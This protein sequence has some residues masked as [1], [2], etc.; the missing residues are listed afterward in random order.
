MNAVSFIRWA[1]A[2]SVLTLAID[3]AASADERPHESAVA[4]D[5][6]PT[7][8]DPLWLDPV[9]HSRTGLLSRSIRPDEA[10]GYF[11]IL[12]HAHQVPQS[13]LQGAARRFEKKRR[14]I[15]KN[16]PDY[17]FYFRDPHAKFP[18][19]FD[20]HQASEAYH[21]KLVT[22]RGHV[23]RLVSFPAGQ[24]AHGFQELHE[25]WLYVDDAQQNPVVI[26]CSEL[27]SGIPTGGDLLVDFVSATGYFFKRYGY[28]DRNGQARFSP[29]ILAQR[30]E[31]SPPS[32][33][34]P[35]LSTVAFFWLVTG[36]A[37][38]IAVACWHAAA[39]RHTP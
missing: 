7:E 10:A 9:K 25:A 24:N 19:F 26:V 2:L 33:R 15:V 21:G 20:L 23:R 16:D 37:V 8:L 35:L 3:G 5:V 6:D 28:E 22:V 13:Q 17:R 27:P 11:A 34:H 12:N 31:W 39:R 4:S 18:T 14:D 38:V 30:L 32:P 1:C 36:I 29:L